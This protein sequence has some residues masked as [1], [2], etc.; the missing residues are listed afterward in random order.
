M[1]PLQLLVHLLAF[2]AVVL[3]LIV[4]ISV[5]MIVTVEVEALLGLQ[6]HARIELPVRL[7]LPLCLHRLLSKDFNLSM[8]HS[9]STR[10]ASLSCRVSTPARQEDHKVRSISACTRHSER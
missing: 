7:P 5:M 4:T 8:R 10:A 9:R 2:V 6:A 3:I 1:H